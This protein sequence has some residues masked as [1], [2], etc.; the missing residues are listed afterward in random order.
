MDEYYSK[1]KQGKRVDKV[2]SSSAITQ[3]ASTATTAG[4]LTINLVQIYEGDENELFM[5]EFANLGIVVE[6][7][8]SVCYASALFPSLAPKFEVSKHVSM[9]AHRDLPSK[10]AV[11]FPQLFSRLSPC[12][13]L[14]FDI[15]N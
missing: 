4:R 15:R 1:P 7:E 11:D 2:V 3:Q 9:S 6:P 12:K 5:S 13:I 10:F 8:L 14:A